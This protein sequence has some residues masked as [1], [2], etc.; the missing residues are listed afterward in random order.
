M[1]LTEDNHASRYRITGY[2]SDAV[3]VNEDTLTGS[4]IISPNTLLSSW[5]VRSATA[6][7]ATHW[8]TVLDLVPD[9][10]L[11]LLGTGEHLVWPAQAVLTPLYERQIGIEIM[12]TPAACRT[13]HLLASQGSHFVAVMI[14]GE[15]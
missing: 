12:T 15:G 3:Q 13:Y 9:P 2:T 5:P 14:V 1:Q 4:F 11:I 10:H 7:N 8:Q 6:L